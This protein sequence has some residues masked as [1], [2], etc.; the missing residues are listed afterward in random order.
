MVLARVTRKHEGQELE[1]GIA[2][3]LGGSERYDEMAIG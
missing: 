2:I 3:N 1:D